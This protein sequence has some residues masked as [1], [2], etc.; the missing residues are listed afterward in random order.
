MD[1]EIFKLNDRSYSTI[2]NTLQILCCIQHY[3]ETNIA[4]AIKCLSAQKLCR[5]IKKKKKVAQTSFVKHQLKKKREQV[6]IRKNV[7]AQQDYDFS[8]DEREENE[9][10]RMEKKQAADIGETYGM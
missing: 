7:D 10:T 4:L 5:L 8:N 1:N 9:V 6:Q 3:F 2:I